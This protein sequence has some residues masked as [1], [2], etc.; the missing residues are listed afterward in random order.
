MPRDRAGASRPAV[1][2]TSRATKTSPRARR[3]QT[4]S[5]SRRSRMP[6]A[7]TTAL[8]FG[9]P[10]GFGVRPRGD[11]DDEQRRGHEQLRA[12]QAAQVAE[13]RPDHESPDASGIGVEHPSHGKGHQ[14]TEVVG[15]LGTAAFILA[16]CVL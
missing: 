11:D 10:R 13:H 9:I 5:S 4:W 12:V 7:A 8:V 15:A 16:S 6:A 3:A 1:L 14:W 2:I